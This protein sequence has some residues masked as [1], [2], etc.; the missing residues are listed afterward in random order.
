MSQP[1]SGHEEGPQGAPPEGAT[2]PPVAAPTAG[3]GVRPETAEIV[4]AGPF[5]D[6]G[7]PFRTDPKSAI[8]LATPGL[9]TWMA[10]TEQ[11]E[12]F[13]ELR[14]RLLHAAAGVGREHFLTIVVPM[15]EHCGGGFVAR[16]LAAAFTLQQRPSLLI[17]C[18][19]RSDPADGFGPGKDAEGLFDFLSDYDDPSMAVPIWP[20][21][22]RGLNVIPAGRRDAVLPIARREYLSSAP[23]KELMDKVR[24]WPCHTFLDAPPAE[25]SPDARILSEFADFVVLV[26]G[27]GR[28]TPRAIAQAAALFD[29]KKLVGA[30]FNEASAAAA[31]TARG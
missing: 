23:M 15:T 16:N 30:V 25:G 9:P 12:A 24:G 18:N 29:R 2:A 19:F 3:G 20:T 17:E 13:R 6:P 27:Y 8:R 31:S 28:V 7:S 21:V 1:D 4:P 11:F 22:L 5:A 10:T 26:V 14:T